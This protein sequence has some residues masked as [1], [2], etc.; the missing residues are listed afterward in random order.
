MGLATGFVCPSSAPAADTPILEVVV[1]DVG[2]GDGIFIRT[3]TKKTYLIDAGP[4]AKRG[5]IP[6]LRSRH[7]SR[8]DAMALTHPH[9]DHIGGAVDVIEFADVGEVLDCGRDHPTPEYRR[10]LE[11][12]KS[13]GIAYRQPRTGDALNWDPLMNVLVLHPDAP[14]YENVNNNSI[15]IRTAYKKISFVFTGDAEEDAEQVIC[16]RFGPSIQADVL[17]VGHHG[18]HTSSSPD[19]LNL[20]RPR[21]ALIS[22]ATGNSFGHPHPETLDKLESIGARILRTDQ[23][24]FLTFRTDGQTI[25]WSR[26][27]L[28]FPRVDVSAGVEEHLGS[29]SWSGH[30]IVRDGTLTL[31]ADPGQNMWTNVS[32][33]P[34]WLR[35]LP[36]DPEWSCEASIMPTDGWKT[37]GGLVLFKN[38]QNFILFGV[39]ENQFVVMS[40]VHK[41]KLTLGP[42]WVTYKPLQI[43]FR[44]T[45]TRLD[46]LVYEESK[47]DWKAVWELDRVDL[48]KFS[49][50]MRLGFYAKSWGSRR[51]E[52]TVRGLRIYRGA[53]RISS[54]HAPEED[55]ESTGPK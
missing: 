2:Q 41:G 23:D 54:A 5:V 18:S 4:D 44:V 53:A 28:P 3:P 21:Y 15:V 20:V 40:V 14:H 52:M 45:P 42:E 10:L 39:Q 49:E 11:T 17:K 12:V 55:R 38:P 35:P 29:P 47:K 19:F 36:E 8:I 9:A 13:H 22:C 7:V 46:A 32:S 43:G 33:A 24:G 30:G 50:N 16:D 1:M 51:A 37:E 27:K 48:P 31:A 6:F 34:M 25:H 26:D